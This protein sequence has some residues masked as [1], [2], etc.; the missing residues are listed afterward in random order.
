MPKS[1]IPNP[2]TMISQEDT[3]HI[4][5]LARLGLKKTEIEKFQK[6]LSSILDYF[7]SLKK[8]D[9]LNVE[10]TFHPVEHFFKERLDIIRQDRAESQTQ[11]TVDKLIDLV[12]EKKGRHVKV[13]AVL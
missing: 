9:V 11:E 6:D 1:Q 7:N 13:K 8:V 4:A 5:K 10:P 3:K 2:K 12:P